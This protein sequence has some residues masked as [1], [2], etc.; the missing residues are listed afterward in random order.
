MRSEH[1][2][3]Q[4]T[5]DRANGS[6]HSGFNSCNRQDQCLPMESHLIC[7][8]LEERRDTRT[9][10]ARTTPQRHFSQITCRRE[11]DQPPTTVPLFMESPAPAVPL[12]F[13]A[14]PGGVVPLG[15]RATVGLVFDRVN[16]GEVVVVIRVGVEAVGDDGVSDDAEPRSF[17]PMFGTSRAVGVQ[18]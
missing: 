5:E 2:R 14:W 6:D 12:P 9:A 11:A 15:D 10:S 8:V 7:Q 4:S 13:T 17:C 18:Y 1:S 3:V 16:A